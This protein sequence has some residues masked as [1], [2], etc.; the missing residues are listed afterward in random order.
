MPLQTLFIKGGSA[1]LTEAIPKN[2]TV[3]INDII[4]S[5]KNQVAFH[6]LKIE[7][8][9]F[10]KINKITFIFSLPIKKYTFTSFK[11][12]LLEQCDDFEPFWDSWLAKKLVERFRVKSNKLH[13][14][15]A[16]NGLTKFKITLSQELSKALGVPGRIIT[17]N[18]DGSMYFASFLEKTSK[19]TSLDFINFQSKKLVSIRCDAV[20]RSEHLDDIVFTVNLKLLKAHQTHIQASQQFFFKLKPHTHWGLTFSA[21]EFLEIHLLTITIN[22]P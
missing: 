16:P 11:R 9:R 15:K 10:D 1:L 14:K 17:V 4:F 8:A 5:V 20:D 18:S 7:C 13:F 22:S 12:H 19:R 21:P 2:S 6:Q 3:A